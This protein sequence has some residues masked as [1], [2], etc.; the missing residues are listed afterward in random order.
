M[1]LLG[2][3]KK[4]TFGQ[5]PMPG[6][7]QGGTGIG[8][9]MIE[10]QQMGAPVQGMGQLPDVANLPDMGG[11]QQ[12]QPAKFK[13]NLIGVIGDAMQVFGGGQA[14]YMNGVREQQQRAELMRERAML[15]QQERQT[16]WQDYV[17]KQE[18]ERDNPAAPQPTEFE[19]I[20]KASGLPEAQQV[21]LMQQYAQN[22]ANPVQG[23]KT[24]DADGN[25]T[26]QF[27]RPSAMGQQSGPQ[28]GATASNPKT[29]EKLVFTNGAWKPAGGSVGNGTGGFQPR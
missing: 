27:M 14:T 29:G 4:Q 28:E 1:A 22:R 8:D 12:Q 11:M 17:R 6:G 16:G 7:Y 5:V 18:Y 19:R 25:E 20:L 15:A 24:Y 9:G 3:R 23:V 2:G 10:H 26:L 21:T 13:P